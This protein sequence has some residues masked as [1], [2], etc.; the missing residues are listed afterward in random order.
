MLPCGIIKQSNRR[1][2]VKIINPS[3]SQFEI[4]IMPGKS[5]SQYIA[6]Q[7]DY[8]KI[9]TDKGFYDNNGNI[10]KSDKPSVSFESHIDLENFDLNILNKIMEQ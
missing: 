1:D 3:N 7:H 8:I 4:R 2:G 10:I 9:K 5:N 6:Q